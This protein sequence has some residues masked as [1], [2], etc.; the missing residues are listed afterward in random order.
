METKLNIQGTYRKAGN[1]FFNEQHLFRLVKGKRL[2]IN[3]KT[4][5]F[6]ILKPCCGSK[7]LPDG[8]KERYVSGIFWKTNNTFNI[9]FDQ[10]RYIVEVT[11]EGLQINPAGGGKGL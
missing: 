10:I 7:L 11:P 4:P 3:N 1:E 8:S 6:L 9:D 2:P 5:E